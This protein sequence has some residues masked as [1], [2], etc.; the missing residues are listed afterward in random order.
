MKRIKLYLVACGVMLYAVMAG[1]QNIKDLM[2]FSQNEYYGTARSIGMGNAMTAIGG[3]LGS[4]GINPAGSAVAN[5]AQI[6]ITPGITI[7]SVSS[8]YSPSGESAFGPAATTNSNR[9]NMPNFGTTLR[10]DTGNSSGLKSFT[11]GFVANMTNQY[12]FSS[13]ASGVNSRSSMLAGI[14][15]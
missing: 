6:T 1:A 13:S 10:F 5:H 11:L 15:I 9:V 12:E 8:R 2:L 14:H 4:I 7:S 3:D